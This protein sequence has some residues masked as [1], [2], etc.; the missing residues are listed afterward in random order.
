MNQ[1]SALVQQS[2]VSVVE[3]NRGTEQNSCRGIKAQAMEQ[4]LKRI[5]LK[6]VNIPWRNNNLS[7]LHVDSPLSEQGE[8]FIGIYLLALGK[9]GIITHI[10]Y[11]F[12]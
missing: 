9:S 12:F 2:P 3:E 8:T 5:P 10:E 1:L 4:M 7:T 11:F 6:V